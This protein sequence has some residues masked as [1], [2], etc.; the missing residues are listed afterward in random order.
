MFFV[1]N[2]KRITEAGKGKFTFKLNKQVRV[3]LTLTVLFLAG[4]SLAALMNGVY[5]P[6]TKY[7]CDILKGNLFNP[8]DTKIATLPLPESNETFKRF[9]YA[10]FV[11]S[12]IHI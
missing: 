9:S 3:S 8:I 4:I 2:V 1:E 5:V 12:L 11:L 6:Q 10:V 7:Y